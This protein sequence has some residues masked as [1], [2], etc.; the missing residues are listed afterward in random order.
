MARPLDLIIGKIEELHQDKC[1][2]WDA[3]YKADYELDKA[4]DEIAKLKK[5]IKELKS[6]SKIKGKL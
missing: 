4:I 6:G 1:A 5:Q 3:F 2:G